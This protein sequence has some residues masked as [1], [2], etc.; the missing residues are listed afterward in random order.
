MTTTQKALAKVDKSGMKSID[1]FFGVEHVLKNWKDLNLW[2]W[3]WT[4]ISS[5]FM[6]LFHPSSLLLYFW[7]FNYH[8]LKKGRMRAIFRFTQT[9][10]CIQI[11]CF[12]NMGKIIVK[13]HG[14]LI[15]FGVYL[16]SWKVIK[17]VELTFSTTNASINWQLWQLKKK[18]KGCQVLLA[19]PQE[20]HETD[21]P[22]EPSVLTT[23]W[24]WTSS[25]Q[26]C[27]RINLLF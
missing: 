25:L 20:R 15:A 6:S 23:P 4:K 16:T 17:S 3:N 8:L 7:T 14:W 13:H 9:F 24:L 26:N 21:S 12:L 18:A 10:L 5:F 1:S 11:L 27:A 22:L 2:K 19:T